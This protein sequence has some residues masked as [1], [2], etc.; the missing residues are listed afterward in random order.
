MKF[1]KSDVKDIEGGRCE[2][3]KDRRLDFS[4]KDRKRIWKN[5]MEEIM[6]KE[7]DWNQVTAVG[8]VKGLI[9]N[10][11][12]KKMSIAIKVI[13]LRKAAWI[14]WSMCRYGIC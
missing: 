1:I 10:I 14:F 11:I 13:K 2:K 8:M 12:R 7:K 5:Y 4:K 6:N 9:K 3:R